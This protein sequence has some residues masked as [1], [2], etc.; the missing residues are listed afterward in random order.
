MPNLYFGV[1]KGVKNGLKMEKFRD[2]SPRPI[3]VCDE[4]IAEQVLEAHSS[5][6]LAIQHIRMELLSPLRFLNWSIPL[7]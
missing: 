7:E 3:F 4:W 2:T 1:L 6:H 5:S